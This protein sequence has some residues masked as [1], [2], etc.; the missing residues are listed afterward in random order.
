MASDE[1]PQYAVLVDGGWLVSWLPRRVLTRDQAMTAMTIAE[2]VSRY[3]WSSPFDPAAD[4]WLF[5]DG[6]AAELGITAANAVAEASL[7]P[8]NR[9]LLGDYKKGM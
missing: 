8:Q 4:I 2:T 1:T 5:I 6:W 7:S 9:A 3:D